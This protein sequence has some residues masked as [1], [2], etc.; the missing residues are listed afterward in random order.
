MAHFFRIVFGVFFIACVVYIVISVRPYKVSGDSMEPSFH[1]W[2]IALIDRLSIKFQPLKR[3]EIIVYRD[4]K[5]DWEARVKRI[6]WLAGEKIEIANGKIMI[7]TVEI[8]EWYLGKNI[9]TC[10]PW[11]CTDTSS[12]IFE[13]PVKSYFVLG[14]N[15]VSSR[16]SRGCTDVANCENKKPIY[17]PA[18]EVLGRVFFSW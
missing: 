12:H 14:D 10:L 11:A 1:D 8:A 9:R 16:D 17:I 3:W 6:L 7:N 15:R 13:I 4:M 5:N 2:E 18:I